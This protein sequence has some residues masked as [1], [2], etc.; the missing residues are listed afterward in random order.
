MEKKGPHYASTGRALTERVTPVVAHH[1]SPPP[2]PLIRF[3]ELASPPLPLCEKH[4]AEMYP[5]EEQRH[6]G[7]TSLSSRLAL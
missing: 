7:R 2:L 4:I 6:A 3:C 5:Y 1:A